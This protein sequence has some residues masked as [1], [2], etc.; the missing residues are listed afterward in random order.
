MRRVESIEGRFFDVIVI[1]GGIVGAGVARDAALR[2]LKVCLLEKNDFGSGTTSGSTRLIHGGLR[3]LEMLDFRLVRLDLREREIL[4]RIAPHLVKPLEFLLPFYEQS[5]L[6]RLKIRSGMILYDLLSYDKSLP[7]HSF[8]TAS[9]LQQA[10][11]QLKRGGLQ[12]AACYHDAQID[13]PERLCLE[14]VLDARSRGACMMNYVE[15]TGPLRSGGRLEGVSVRDLASGE[16]L[17]V[18]GR[19][20]VNVAGPWLDRVLG[21][22][23]HSGRPRIRT[24]KGVHLACRKKNDRAMVFFSKIDQRLFFVIPWLGYSW[25]GTTDTDFSNDPSD[26]RATGQDVRYLLQSAQEFLP[27]LRADDIYFTNAGVRALVMREGGESSVTRMHRVVDG[28]ALG[29]P[30]LIAVQGGKITGY[31]AIAEEVTDLISAKLNVSAASRTAATP[32][33]GAG[34][35]PEGETDGVFPTR[36]VEHLRSIYG[37]RSREIL[38]LAEAEPELGERLALE[39]PDIA[40]QAVFAVRSELCLRLSDFFLRRTRLGF[41]PDQGR[42]AA[43]GAARWMA[44][45]LQWSESR[46]EEEIQAYLDEIERTQTFRDELEESGAEAPRRSRQDRDVTETP[47]L[48]GGAGRA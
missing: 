19:L 11:P 37:S 9:E 25:V 48:S 17:E 42:R 13:L 8:W 4:L 16:E 27:D 1:G 15:A 3:Y 23:G 34:E 41:A 44:R 12:G 36:L 47:A 30:G 35:T 18:R 22:M 21:Q 40:A 24:T 31:R 7:R 10:E 26:A 20:I 38:A 5:L 45:E 6:H 32:L 43:R 2:G 39:Y 14:N 28:E 46:Q 29:L 33:P